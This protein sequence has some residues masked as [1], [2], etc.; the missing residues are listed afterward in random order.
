METANYA[1]VG[2]RA[3]GQARLAT[4][5]GVTTTIVSRA[6]AGLS[7]PDIGGILAMAEALGA[8]P[9]E[10]LRAAGQAR[11]VELIEKRSAATPAADPE[12]TLARIAAASALSDEQRAWLTGLYRRW[13]ARAERQIGQDISELIDLMEGLPPA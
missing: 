5:A 4:A 13:L 10:G 9:V 11:L 1:T 2:K 6:L 8:D 12:P 7:T 3:G